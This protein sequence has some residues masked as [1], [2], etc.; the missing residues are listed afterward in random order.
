M[1]N[2]IRY[3]LEE[4]KLFETRLEVILTSL[5]EE[6][7]WKLLNNVKISSR[8]ERGFS[9]ID[10]VLIGNKVCYCIEAKDW[11]CSIKSEGKVFWIL[12]YFREISVLSPIVQN[13]HHINKL[14]EVLGQNIKFD[15]LVC[16]SER[17]LSK[18]KSI[19]TYSIPTLL[20]YL[21]KEPSVVSSG[22]KTWQDKITAKLKFI[23]LDTEL[24]ELYE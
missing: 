15:N 14:R 4:G 17:L 7:S 21:E 20:Q 8:G 6:K 19:F 2:K 16:F 23:T 10:F 3:R 13:T 22:V 24:G 12:D 18:P 11:N 5:C 9:Q 1:N